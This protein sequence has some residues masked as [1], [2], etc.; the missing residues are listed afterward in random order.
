MHARS[1]F[2]A[3]TCVTQYQ[4]GGDDGGVFTGAV[5]DKHESAQWHQLGSNPGP[6]SCASRT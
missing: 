5:G 4:L 3:R 6:V 1:Y 2:T